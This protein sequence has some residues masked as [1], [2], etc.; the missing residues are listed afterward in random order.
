MAN[1]HPG[2]YSGQ[3]AY[4]DMLITEKVEKRKVGGAH[5]DNI[6]AELSTAMVDGSG[7]GSC[8]DGLQGSSDCAYAARRLMPMECARLQGFPPDWCND[9]PHTDSAEYKLWGNG[10]SLPCLIPMMKSMH[11]ILEEDLKGLQ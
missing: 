4:S 1:S 7:T 3:D 8:G 10:I 6:K 11:D 5:M 2:S 9:V